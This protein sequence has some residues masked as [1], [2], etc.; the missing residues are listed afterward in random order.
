M[1]PSLL[2]SLIISQLIVCWIAWTI[3][4]PGKRTASLSPT[5]ISD[6]AR[7]LAE[8]SIAHRDAYE[9]ARELADAKQ[10][11]LIEWDA[12]LEEN[13]RLRRESQQELETVR[14]FLAEFDEQENAGLLRINSQHATFWPALAAL[15][16]LVEPQTGGG[17]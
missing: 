10:E 3:L 8:T 14:R 4:H 12:L 15:R 17:S 13:D 1:T 5:N 7:M 2:A 6:L 11:L 16:S 9:L